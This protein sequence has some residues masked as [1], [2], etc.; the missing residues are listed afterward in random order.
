MVS[1]NYDDIYR[2]LT[3]DELSKAPEIPVSSD[4]DKE[5]SLFITKNSVPSENDIAEYAKY[6]T[7]KHS[8]GNQ[9]VENELMKKIFIS[10]ILLKMK[11]EKSA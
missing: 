6:L 8:G 5:I 3:G 4:I 10:V 11:K 9:S 2:K 7:L 1:L